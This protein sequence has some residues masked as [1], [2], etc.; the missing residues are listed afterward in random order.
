MISTVKQWSRRTIRVSVIAILAV[1]ACT[2]SAFASGA[3]TQITT[4]PA[5]E[6]ITVNGDYGNLQ[7]FFASKC[8]GTPKGAATGVA[9]L[10]VGGQDAGGKLDSTGHT[11]V[12]VA[13]GA[14]VKGLAAN[15]GYQFLLVPAPNGV[16]D[17]A[18][19]TD[20]AVGSGNGRGTATTKG[21]LNPMS[22]ADVTIPYDS[23][24]SNYGCGDWIIWGRVTKTTGAGFGT[25]VGAL[26]FC[27]APEPTA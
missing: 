8:G 4:G 12:P 13:F 14:N 19:A 17:F 27:P 10:G 1:L 26:T 11:V 20:L 2:V 5:S 9:Q 22:A 24:N 7:M 6:N 25:K 23:T 18:H 15:K 3:F 21:Y 16:C